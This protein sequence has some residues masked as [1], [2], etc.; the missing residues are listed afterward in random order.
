MK[1]FANHLFLSGVLIFIWEFVLGRTNFGGIQIQNLLNYRMLIPNA[2]KSLSSVFLFINT[3][4]RH[5]GLQ[6][7]KKLNNITIGI[8]NTV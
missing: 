6:N 4:T 8:V 1:M 3:N 7:M 5:G 2:I